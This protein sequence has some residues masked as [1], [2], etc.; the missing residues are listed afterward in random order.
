MVAFA[1]SEIIDQNEVGFY[2]CTSRCVRRAFLCGKDP[3]S[4]KN[5]GYRRDWILERIKQLA[6]LQA[7]DV[8]FV[9]ILSNHFHLILRNRPDLA[10][11]W[12]DQEVMRRAVA[13]YPWKFK[14]YGGTGDGPTPKQLKQLANDHKLVAEMR[15]RL[16]SISWFM[17]NL[18]QSIAR[19]AN[20]ED[21][22]RGHFWQERFH[23]TPL[24]DE[25]ALLMC[26]VY[27]DLNE[28][29]A[30]LAD[31]P[32][33]SQYTSGFARIRGMKARRNRSANALQND[34]WLS[35]LSL[36]D[37]DQPHYPLAG[38]PASLRAS[39]RGVLDMPLGEYLKILDFSGRQYSKGKRGNIPASLPPILARLGLTPDAW[40]ACVDQ[41]EEVF[42]V[43]AGRADQVKQFNEGRGRKWTCGATRLES[44]LLDAN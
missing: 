42:G 22:V 6:G 23:S 1:R 21:E 8:A 20:L 26:A 36:T 41:F 43:A 12:S 25:I 9:A 11:Q 44:L 7:V 2:H 19:R 28:V 4:G 39:D 14:A 15:K 10:G 35:P 16:S 38:Q 13:S 17:R 33:T 31:R 27:V 18:D 34:G 32:E 5:Y 3:L 29:R 40:F 37:N 30:G 24:L